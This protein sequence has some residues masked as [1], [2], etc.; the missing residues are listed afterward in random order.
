MSD[1][2]RAI[3]EAARALAQEGGP[4]I[5]ITCQEILDRCYLLHWYNG[6]EATAVPPFVVDMGR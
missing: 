6:D 2:I 5:Q 4:A 1:H 3:E